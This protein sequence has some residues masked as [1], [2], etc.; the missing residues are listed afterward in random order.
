M[1]YEDLARLAFDRLAETAGVPG[2]DDHFAVDKWE[3]PQGVALYALY[4]R[5]LRKGDPRDLAFL[6][7]WF[8][9]GIAA[10][11]PVRNVN[12]TAPLLALACLLDHDPRPEWSKLCLEWAEWVMEEMPRTEEGGLQHITSHLVNSGELWADTLFMTV[13]FL[14]KAGQAFGRPDFVEEASY[15]FLLHLR[16]LEDPEAGLWFHGWTFEG[17]HHFG[18]VHWAR[19]NAWFSLAAVEF[20]EI[21]KPRGALRRSIEEAFRTQMKSLALLQAEDGLWHTILDDAASYTETSA[22]AGLAYACRRGIALGILPEGWRD[23]SDRATRGVVR[24]MDAAGIVGG[25]SHGTS[26]GLDTEH[27]R[28]IP[29]SP[30]AYGQGLAFLLLNDACDPPEESPCH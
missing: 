17:R 10:G 27:Y 30:T 22:S 25:V 11:L 12:T 26:L 7:S 5:F 14:A 6:S 19:G 9:R 23:M 29:I 13:L 24:R 21:A 18:R 4:K 2:C 8:E 15:Q 28:R 3:W 20:L 1:K 16:Y